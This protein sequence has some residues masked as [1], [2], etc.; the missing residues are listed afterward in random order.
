MI[1]THTVFVEMAEA[2]TAERTSKAT[3]DSE[4]TATAAG[5]VR[6]ELT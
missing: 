1:E 2:G 4:V 3:T 5:N 6:L